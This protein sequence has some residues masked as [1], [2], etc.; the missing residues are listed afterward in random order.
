MVLLFTFVVCI[1]LYFI[2]FH[3]HFPVFVPHLL[4]SNAVDLAKSKIL[5][6]GTEIIDQPFT[7]QSQLLTTLGKHCRKGEK[8][9]APLSPLGQSQICHVIE[10]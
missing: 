10:G 6:V 1:C 3:G 4:S 2:S 9:L 5:S 8:W 7:T